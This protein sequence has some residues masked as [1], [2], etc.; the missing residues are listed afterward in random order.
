MVITASLLTYGLA[1]MAVEVPQAGEIRTVLVQQNNDP[2]I[3]GNEEKA[4]HEAQNLSREGLSKS[5][6]PTS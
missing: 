6:G 4:L 1:R 3:E 2:W 5:G